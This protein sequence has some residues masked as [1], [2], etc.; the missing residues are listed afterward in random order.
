MTVPGQ[1]KYL[2]LSSKI[3]SAEQLPVAEFGVFPQRPGLK[4][5]AKDIFILNQ[6]TSSW[7]F[8]PISI[9]LVKL[10]HF[11]KQGSK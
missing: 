2:D 1:I 11:P 10:D 4:L 6:P 7:W 5:K 9:I 3:N 8:Q